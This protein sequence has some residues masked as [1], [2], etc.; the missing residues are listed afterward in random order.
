MSAALATSHL[1]EK[2]QN[3]SQHREGARSTSRVSTTWGRM[4]INPDTPH[5][6]E[7]TIPE[8]WLFH[9]ELG[10]NLAAFCCPVVGCASSSPPSSWLTYTLP[11]CGTNQTEWDLFKLKFPGRFASGSSVMVWCA[12][13]TFG[14]FCC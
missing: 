14:T 11:A 9:A 3:N 4:G 6:T 1:L 7:N 5:F 10:T 8:A 12:I 13:L 2:T